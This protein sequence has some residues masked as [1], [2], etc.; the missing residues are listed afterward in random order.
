MNVFVLCTG[1]CG[2][3]TFIRA[4][5][6]I[7]NYNAAHES[8]VHELGIERV[9]YPGKHIE[10]DHYLA[11]FLGKLDERYGD[12][13]RYV[14]LMRDP[15][16]VALSFSRRVHWIGSLA[17]AYK[18]G[19]LRVSSAPYI[20]A[21]RD[22]VETVNTN[23]RHFLNNKTHKMEFWLENAQEDWPIF[24]EWIG[25]QGNYDASLAEWAVRHNP[26]EPF[27]KRKT[28]AVEQRL[29]RAWRALFP[30]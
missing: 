7:S 28:R 8:R 22:Q 10:A 30:R 26:T 11:W 16:T 4:C 6:H 15:E 1:R 24:W 13:A 5:S 3:T 12:N 18:Y 19:L 2:S 29:T 21:C 23:I 17:F 25:A 9:N 14:H 20:E 27:L